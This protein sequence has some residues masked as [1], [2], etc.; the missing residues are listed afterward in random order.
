MQV[1]EL[2]ISTNS[3]HIGVYSVVRFYL[4]LSKRE[5]LPL[6]KGMYNL[7]FLVAKVFDREGNGAFHTVKVIID[8]EALEHEEWSCDTTETEFRT[9]ILLEELLDKFDSLFRLLHVKQRLV[10]CWFYQFTH[11]FI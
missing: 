2:F 11:F 8:A 6:G 7:S 5:T 10:S 3:I 1:V 9:N 4:V